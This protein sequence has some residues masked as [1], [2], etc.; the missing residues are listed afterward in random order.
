MLLLI[1]KCIESKILLKTLLK[2]DQTFDSLKHKFPEILADLTSAR[3]NS[4][5]SCINK[6]KLYLISKLKNEEE[7]IEYAS[8]IAEISDDKKILRK[9]IDY[10]NFYY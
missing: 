4:N 10:I 8:K 7:F 5:C 3:I 9:K 6:V 1:E 2:H